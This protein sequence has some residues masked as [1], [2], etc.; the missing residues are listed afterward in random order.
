MW[1]PNPQKLVKLVLHSD[2]ADVETPWAED[3]GPAHGEEGRRLLRLGNVP[4][5]HAKPTYEDVVLAER[6][7]DGRW[8]WDTRGA[9]YAAVCS[10]LAEDAGRWTMIVTY[11]LRPSYADR[12]AAFQAM[13]R[14]GEAAD[15][16]VEGESTTADGRGGRAY[17]A[18]PAE[19]GVAKAL[20]LLATG[21]LDL[22]LQHPREDEGS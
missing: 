10:R 5:L 13:D 22:T 21:A 12:T 1:L 14:A 4:Y 19:L 3:L 11:A 2:G 17:V 18:V 9:P 6:G 7:E 20:Q 8:T 15:M 16:V